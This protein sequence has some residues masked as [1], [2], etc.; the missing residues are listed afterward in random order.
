MVRAFSS[1]SVRMV[2][3]PLAFFAWLIQVLGSLNAFDASPS[4]SPSLP[5]DHI[6]KSIRQF[7]EKFEGGADTMMDYDPDTSPW[8]APSEQIYGAQS[9]HYPSFVFSDPQPSSLSTSPGGSDFYS[10]QASVGSLISTPQV[11]SPSRFHNTPIHIAPHSTNSSSEE[12]P[13]ANTKLS[14]RSLTAHTRACRLSP[15]PTSHQP[16]SSSISYFCTFCDS[17]STFRSKHEW[18]RHERS[19]VP[20]VEYTCLPR[21]A[22]ISL[23]GRSVCVIC[24]A[25]EPRADHMNEHKMHLCLYKPAED[26]TFSR[27]DKFAKHLR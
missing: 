18:K 13:V 7:N 16:R 14:G 3:F 12:T 6:P 25:R 17:S 20:Q 9:L 23:R 5:F 22:V 24:S 10:A 8:V 2:T 4:P 19:H 26:R 1:R 21:G 27:K 15:S 11:D